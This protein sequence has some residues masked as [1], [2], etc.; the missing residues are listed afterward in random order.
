MAGDG[1]GAGTELG[2]YYAIGSYT[3]LKPGAIHV[4]QAQAGE[5]DLEV[6]SGASLLEKYGLK[7]VQVKAD[8]VQGSSNDAALA[9]LNQGGGTAP[10]WKVLIQGGDGTAGSAPLASTG[11]VLGFKTAQTVDG[12]ID[13]ATNVICTTYCFKSNGFIVDGSGNITGLYDT[14]SAGNTFKIAGTTA[15]TVAQFQG[16]LGSG[17]IKYVFRGINFNQTNTDNAF[18]LILPTGITRY[19]VNNIRLSNASAS[20]ST[21]TV[22]MFTAT[23]G[24]GQTIAANQAITITQTAAD[25]NNNAMILTLTNGNTMAYTDTTLQF[26][27]GTA[28][29]APATADVILIIN[30]L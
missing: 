5:F 24:G 7:V 22:G 1:G 15:G 26:R 13:L 2:Y 19:T 6:D 30:P 3:W 14:G 29:G 27:L 28:Q 21:A 12:G 10:G 4:V 20:I 25:T 11:K 17:V 9:I 18:T 8:A 16:V 23:G